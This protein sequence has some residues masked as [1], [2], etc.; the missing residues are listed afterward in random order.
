[1][2]WWPFIILAALI[3]PNARAHTAAVLHPV[4]HV[5][6]WVTVDGTSVSLRLIT[7]LDDV[8]RFQKPSI[9][10]DGRIAPGVFR[11]AVADH[12]AWLLKQVQIFDQHGRLL[13][14]EVLAVP[15]PEGLPQ[16]IDPEGDANI[17][18]TWRMRLTS[19]SRLEALTFLP[20]LGHASLIAPPE[21]R[22]HI[23]PPN[24][25]RRIDAVV[26]DNMPHTVVF[27]P[28]S[29]TIPGATSPF[30]DQRD[31]NAASVLIIRS[32]EDVV[33]E[34]STPATMLVDTALRP[35]SPPGTKGVAVWDELEMQRIAERIRVQHRDGAVLQLVSGIRLAPL[36]V[37]VRFSAA[38]DNTQF[39]DLD[40][41][42]QPV[43]PAALTISVRCVYRL[44]P[45]QIVTEFVWTGALTATQ[46]VNVTILRNA[47]SQTQV[48]SLSDNGFSVDLVGTNPLPLA[49]VQPIF[50]E[51]DGM[52]WSVVQIWPTLRSR[53]LAVIVLSGSL[54]AVSLR[55]WRSV[56]VIGIAGLSVIVA[57]AVVAIDVQHQRVPDVDSAERITS[58][59]LAAAFDGAAR[60]PTD[61][62]ADALLAVMDPELAES[63]FLAMRR[64]L[65]Q[66]EQGDAGLV[67]TTSGPDLTV[68]DC[69]LLKSELDGF[70]VRGQWTLRGRVLHW[71]HLHD[72]RRRFSGSL[73]VGR[74]EDW[75]RLEGVTLT[76]A[77]VEDVLSKSGN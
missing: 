36:D 30:E 68:D 8:I 67:I 12:A 69:T 77:S 35:P 7:F 3:V 31:I 44:L 64:S 33:V 47:D 43:N 26:F 62:T 54:V 10:P 52:P 66:V 1:M 25:A 16:R 6:A 24:N 19:D 40:D 38:F 48:L 76:N 37:E 5:D 63:V 51:R 61:D 58:S 41:L 9:S 70:V 17:R 34:L 53:V 42:T 27:D 14:G 39:I 20:R 45:A 2:S 59:L 73:Q 55:I 15:D 28:A 50:V 75:W 74:F 46:S 4:S 60:P 18:L 32:R 13:G 49:D 72:Q 23:R 57:L 21:L 56:W 65:A 71:G 11:A 22:L 29:Q